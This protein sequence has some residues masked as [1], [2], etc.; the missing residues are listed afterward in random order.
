MVILTSSLSH[1]TYQ[2]LQAPSSFQFCSDIQTFTVRQELFHCGVTIPPPSKGGTP[3]KEN[4]ILLSLSLFLQ[5][6]I[7]LTPCCSETL[8]VSHLTHLPSKL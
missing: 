6:S 3:A 2:D 1:P 4:S 8:C 7:I 5:F